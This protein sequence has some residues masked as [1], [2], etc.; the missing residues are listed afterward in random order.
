VHTFLFRSQKRAANLDKTQWLS[1]AACYSGGME[2][3]LALLIKPFVALVV[4]GLICLPARFALQRH[5]PDGKLKRF[6]LR[7]ISR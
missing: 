7:P 5:M 2:W 3:L 1:G 4:F 6:L